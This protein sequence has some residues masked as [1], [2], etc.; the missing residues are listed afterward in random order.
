MIWNRRDV[1]GSAFLSYI[2]ATSKVTARP[3]SS[4]PFGLPPSLPR[5]DLVVGSTAPD[6]LGLGR[7]RDWNTGEIGGRIRFGGQTG[8]MVWGMNGSG[9]DTRLLVPI[10][11]QSEGLSIF[12]VDVKGE[13]AAVTAPWLRQRARQ[14]G[15][16][17][18]IINPY[19]LHVDIPGYE[20]L[21]SDGFNPLLPLDVD[22]PSFST[23]C[24]Y[25]ADA[26]IEA[27]QNDSGNAKHFINSAKAMLH[28]SIMLEVIRAKRDKRVPLMSNVR[29]LIC[30]PSGENKKSKSNG[31]GWPDIAR[32]MLQ[33][34]NIPLGNL[35]SQFTNWNNE[36]S[37]IASDAKRQTMMFDDNQI[38]RDLIKGTFDFREMKQRPVTVFLMLPPLEM[39]RQAPY[40]RMVVDIALRA[41]MR[42]RG[43]G[44]PKCLFML[45]EFRTMGK[46]EVLSD[47]WGAV[48]GFG[49]Q[50]MPILQSYG[51]LVSLY[52]EQ[53]A[54]TFV[55]QAGVLASFGANHFDTARFLS[56]RCGEMTKVVPSYSYSRSTNGGQVSTNRQTSWSQQAAPIVTPH[57]AMNMGEGEML[58]FAAT[59]GK[60]IPAY[61]PSY[62]DIEQCAERARANPFHL[63]GRT[64]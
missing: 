29:L 42:P 12:A 55:E 20:D 8:I 14:E 26:I 6:A 5:H 63:P 45:N 40:L 38:A 53:D 11:L 25:I 57:D 16:R 44:E 33:T 61:A 51:Q 48:R 27:A 32:E 56:E 36:V 50:L 37:G 7:Y 60:F 18:V 9:K 23:S 47:V 21:K 31:Y 34:G 4:D 59:M 2:G 10:L 13:M 52:G 54:K 43:P 28:A 58:Q 35:A 64:V 22:D 39:R 24:S 49:I 17:V 19:G 3:R 30:T 62:W 46:L 41:L 1:I 15:G